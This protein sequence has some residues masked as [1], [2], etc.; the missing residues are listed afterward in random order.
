[1]TD[2]VVDTLR[3]DY[4]SLPDYYWGQVT[5]RRAA[6]AELLRVRLELAGLVGYYGRD[7]AVPVEKLVALAGLA[8]TSHDGG[9]E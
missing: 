2:P 6:E 3:A 1:M 8:P 9:G 7:G 4:P 5:E